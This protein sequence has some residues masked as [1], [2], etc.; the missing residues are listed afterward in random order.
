M[1]DLLRQISEGKK[2]QNSTIENFLARNKSLKRYSSSFRL[3]WTI[4]V[5]RGVY[6]PH[7][8]SDQIADA[9]V[10]LFNFSPA[11]SRNAYSAVL[12][13]P[14]IGVGLRFHPLL[15]P[16]KREWS[17]NVEKYASFWDPEPVLRALMAVPFHNSIEAQNVQTLRLHVILSC[18]LL[19]LY[20]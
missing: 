3:L 11:Q 8:S 16:F 2:L 9:I 6:P 5:K 13:L 20:R 4:L 12:L 10:Q 15:G 17:K 14:G 1:P 7:T 18:R 19:C